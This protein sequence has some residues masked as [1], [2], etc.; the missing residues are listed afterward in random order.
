[1]KK[2]NYSKLQKRPQRV[3]F[4]FYAFHAFKI[5]QPSIKSTCS[6]FTVLENQTT[7]QSF[8]NQ[9]LLVTR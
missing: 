7:F 5:A 9:K 6:F 8:F 2:E 1:M 4:L 3:N